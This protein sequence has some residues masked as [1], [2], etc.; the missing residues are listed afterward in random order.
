M[1]IEVHFTATNL[2]EALTDAA[3]ESMPPDALEHWTVL[4]A[5]EDRYR[6]SLSPWIDGDGKITVEFDTEAGSAR[7]LRRD[8]KKRVYEALYK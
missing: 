3:V 2:R 1:K 7:V 6:E 4:A 5:R 8:G